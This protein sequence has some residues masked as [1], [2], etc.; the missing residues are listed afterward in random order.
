M[1]P[2]YNS[3]TMP[4]KISKIKKS[5]EHR[6]KFYTDLSDSENFYNDAESNDSLEVKN[7]ESLND[8]NEDNNQE[9]VEENDAQKASS[10]LEQVVSDLLMQKEGFQKVFKRQRSRSKRV[11][12]HWSKSEEELPTKADSLP[13]SFQLSDK[14][15]DDDNESARLED[16][17]EKSK[18][19]EEIDIY[20]K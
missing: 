20:E 19:H 7:N 17:Y 8:I 11:E 3:K 15:K 14:S 4:K 2:Q 12:E 10:T 5:K 1:I 13:R 9:V 16:K 18:S 6:A